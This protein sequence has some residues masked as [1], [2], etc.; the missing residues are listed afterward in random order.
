M[1]EFFVLF[2][3]AV[4]AFFMVDPFL[5]GQLGKL[6]ATKALV[7]VLMF[8]SIAFHLFG[9]L[10]S[11]QRVYR[12]VIRDVGR[13][14]WPLIGLS[15]IIIGGSSYARWVSDIRENF[16]TTGLAMLML[17]LM[18][19]VVLTAANPQRTLRAMGWIYAVMVIAKVP[20]LI[21]GTNI[22]HEE[23]F[24]FIPLAFWLLV[25]PNVRFWQVLGGV[26][27][28]AFALF[29]FKNTTFII[30]LSSFVVYAFV[31]LGRNIGRANRLER[32][33]YFYIVGAVALLAAT[34]MF[35]AWWNI[36]DALPSGN[37][38]YRQEMYSIAWAKFLKSPLWGTMYT[39]RSVEY[40]S[41]YQVGDGGTNY[42]PTHSD[43]LDFLANGGVIA[44][45]LWALTVKR[46]FSMLAMSSRQLRDRR[47]SHREKQW[48]Y[49]W[50]LGLLQVGAIIT[51]ALNPPLQSANHGLWI[52]GSLGVMWAVYRRVHSLAGRDVRVEPRQSQ[53]QAL[54]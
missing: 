3:L 39:T 32:L 18:A 9:R 42:L 16:L 2:S 45:A 29:S 27:L 10:I 19:M 15:L 41:L 25:A 43:I 21:A 49:V 54:A 13:Q 17:P 26:A 51:Y 53:V 36:K 28:I 50:V 24:L 1:T 48:R 22:Y 35:V 44:F 30:I 20:M 40:F 33:T 23:V 46:M 34:L 11:D 7:F 12:G 31:L 52:W 8:G 4:S 6:P 14:W 5:G 47:N 37:T 38:E